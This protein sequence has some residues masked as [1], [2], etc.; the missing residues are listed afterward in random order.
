MFHRPQDPILALLRL[1][2]GLTK[3][4]D[5]HAKPALGGAIFF[6]LALPIDF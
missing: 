6:V 1:P 2:N 3:C 5:G 4:I